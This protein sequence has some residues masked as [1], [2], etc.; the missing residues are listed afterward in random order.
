M[1]GLKGTFYVPV[2]LPVFT[3]CSHAYDMH[4]VI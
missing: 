3:Q 4:V 2:V 1:P